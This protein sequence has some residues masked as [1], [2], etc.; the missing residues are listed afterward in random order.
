MLK[1]GLAFVVCTLCLLGLDFAWLSLTT[2]AL[3]RPA[4]GSL[5]R[6]DFNLAPGAGFYVI[7]ALALSVL[8]IRPALVQR[9]GYGEL[10]LKSAL[11]GLA[12]FATYDLTALAVIRDWPL[13]L[14]FIDIAWGTFAAVVACNATALILKLLR[15]A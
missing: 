13:I 9:W 4:M 2:E 11:L 5:L 3:Y 8:V 1:T 14:S 6:T 7:Y 10:T 12:A 15:Q